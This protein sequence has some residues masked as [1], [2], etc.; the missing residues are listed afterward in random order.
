[1][2]QIEVHLFSTLREKVGKGK[3][4]IDARNIKDALRKLENKFGD[5]FREE[6]YEKG[7]I[8]SHYIFLLNGRVI[9]V[10]ALSQTKLSPGDIL[11][12]MPPV[13]GG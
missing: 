6:L 2:S 12:I 1:M 5:K 13:A 10:K 7:R 11:H 9:D 3:I 4:S 8:K